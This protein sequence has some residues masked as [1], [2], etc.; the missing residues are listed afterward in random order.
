MSTRIQL[1]RDT[2]AAWTTANPVLAVGE[3]G[4]E[5]NTGKLKAG[6][7]ATAWVS[8]AYLIPDDLAT[9]TQVV[10]EQQ[11]RVAA[12]QELAELI[13]D[14]STVLGQRVDDV[15][16]D[17]ADMASGLQ[18]ETTARV[19]AIA[20]EADDRIAAVAAEAAARVAAL[21]TKADLVGGLVPT[22]QIPAVA[23]G[24]T[25]TVALQAEMLALTA[26]QVQ[27]GDI[28]IRADQ[29]GRRWLLA[30][31]GDAS[32]L[33][34]WIQL[35]VPDA[36]S[37]VNGQGGTVVLGAADVGAPTIAAL[38]AETD[39]ATAAEGAAQAKADAAL[40]AAEKGAAN[41]VV[42]ADA[43]GKVSVQ[44]LPAL[45]KSDVGLA[46]VDN[47]ADA[48]KPVSAP[49]RAAV[50]AA[51]AGAAMQ[52]RAP[53]S[54]TPQASVVTSFQPGHGWF[55]SGTGGTLV[56]DTSSFARGNQCIKLTTNATG[57]VLYVKRNS[58]APALDMTGKQF[59]L[60]VRIPILAE[61]TNILDLAFYAGNDNNMTVHFSRFY[62]SATGPELLMI[63]PG[64]TGLVLN[65]G[66]MNSTGAPNRAAISAIW[67]RAR[68]Q[69]GAPVNVQFGGLDIIPEPAQGTISFSLDDGGLS[70]YTEGLKKLSQHGFPATAHIIRNVITGE[71]ANPDG[72]FMS[73]MTKG[74]LR[75]LQDR[76]GW[77]IACHADTIAVHNLPNGFVDCSAEL[78]ESEFSG[79]KSWLA[80]NG[81][82]A[83]G[84]TAY[85][86]GRHN[87][88]VY[89]VASR[90]FR[91]ARTT[92]T[93]PLCESW[94]PTDP[95]R[96]TM[97]YV[98]HD[99][100]FAVIQAEITRARQA[101]KWLNICFHNI[102][103][104][105]NP[106]N[107]FTEVS[108][109][110]FGQIVDEV[111]AQVALGGLSVRTVAD[112]IENGI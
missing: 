98:K 19:S 59:R 29:A 47:T 97:F 8:L 54:M 93:V 12:D 43:T 100:T 96:L 14:A 24:Q 57:G 50:D 75:E 84:H 41:G 64:W 21:T 3:L 94:P 109:T 1:R 4:Y 66:D 90:H 83:G 33:A 45:S 104:T 86:K 69:N 73:T 35:E 56:Q 37:A 31:S 36:V 34:N 81:F 78:L 48:A 7:G 17:Q 89:D 102:V 87:Q 9:S 95:L 82:H 44:D 53:R 22:S 80:A 60:W 106:V 16:G 51:A 62:G 28:A 112:V 13:T 63:E 30:H 18:N 67:L 52:G 40:P 85:P 92:S 58:I 49:Q 6:D 32:V 72:T 39:R 108:I 88:L 70:Q 71:P 99:T 103:T 42:Q 26:E 10:T 105:P 111:A 77:D 110:L 107:T 38:T 68:D 27:Q 65:F 61:H 23:T 101:K 11:A 46:T 55:L 76:H 25:I 79:Q 20:Q 91:S 74:M 15:E 2:A 5:T